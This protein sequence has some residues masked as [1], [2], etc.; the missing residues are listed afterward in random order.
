VRLRPLNYLD[1]IMMV[2]GDAKN[3][4][5]DLMKRRLPFRP[6]GVDA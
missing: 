2:F 6:R 5:E 1:K 3:A 4:A